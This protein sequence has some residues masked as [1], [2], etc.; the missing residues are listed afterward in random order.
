MGLG[1]FADKAKD[2]IGEDQVNG[3]ADKAGDF[4]NEKTGNQ[5]EDQVQ[6][7]TDALKDKFGGGDN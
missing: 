5:H 2:S 4:A 7:G 3:A 1:D 6:Q